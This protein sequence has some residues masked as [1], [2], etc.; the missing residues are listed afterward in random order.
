MVGIEKINFILEIIKNTSKIN[1]PI[2]P[3][4]HIILC[5]KI[6]GV[7]LKLSKREP[8]SPFQV[9]NTSTTRF[10]IPTP[11]VQKTQIYSRNYKK[12]E[13]MLKK[14]TYNLSIYDFGQ[15]KRRCFTKKVAVLRGY[16][17]F[18]WGEQIHGRK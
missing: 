1:L 8:P 10:C 2:T 7:L 15:I 9:R 17:P 5:R 4:S 14:I 18:L 12:K 13:K 11:C 16:C 6:V 3:R